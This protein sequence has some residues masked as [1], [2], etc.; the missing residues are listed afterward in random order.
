MKFY[1]CLLTN[2]KQT[3]TFTKK[4]KLYNLPKKE[5]IKI[6][7]QQCFKVACVVNVKLFLWTDFIMI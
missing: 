1:K 4:K 2:H 5:L 3:F 6:L 7:A